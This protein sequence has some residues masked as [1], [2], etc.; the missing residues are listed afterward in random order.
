MQTERKYWKRAMNN[1]GF[2][3]LDKLCSVAIVLGA[4]STMVWADPSSLLPPSRWAMSIGKADYSLEARGSALDSEGAHVELMSSEGRKSPFG[5]S[6][7]NVNAAD[8]RGHTVKLS[9][10]IGTS[11]ARDGS[12]IW[13]RADGVHGELS[14]ANSQASLVKGTSPP[15]KREIEIVVPNSATVLVFGTLL[16]G[17]GRS[18]ADHLS[19]V[20][21]DAVSLASIVPARDELD[22]AI[23]IVKENALHSSSIDWNLEIPKLCAQ[24]GND[25][26]SL[27]TYPL[28]RELLASLQD[29]HSHL[30]SAKDA[31]SNHSATT[32]ISLPTVE[33]R[34]DGAGYIALPGFNN[35]EKHNV[36]AYEG[37]ASTEIVRTA[38]SVST[39]WI[40]DLRND[41]GG[42]MWPM[43]AALRPF[44]G[45]EP[46]GYFKDSFS[47][48][49]PWEVQLRKRYPRASI[50]LSGAPVAVLTGP[51]TASAGEA[52]VIAFKGRPNTRFFGMPTAGVPT[53]NRVFR[54]PDGAAIALTTS[55]ELDRFQKQYDGPIQPDVIIAPDASSGPDSDNALVAALKWLRHTRSTAPTAFIRSGD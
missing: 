26:G 45:D 14:F 46:L 12:G 43:L 25:D 41:R 38:G 39:G 40:I 7:S 48:S 53:G 19:L 32:A 17:D 2:K 29:H 31:D 49:S 24:I 20:R 11:G 22:A 52:V 30:L 35:V 13:I 47:L 4:F 16:E 34:S 44:L 18:V 8:Y 36:E 10:Y 55:V 27:D 23:K 42:N 21:G 5:G 37:S 33:Q 3:I 1:V 15:Q 51:H 28:I 9:A 54:L 6:A 50:D